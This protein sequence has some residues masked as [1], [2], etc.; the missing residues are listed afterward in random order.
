[1]AVPVPATCVC[2]GGG[3][4]VSSP[5]QPTAD[6]E[7][8]QP[9]A[10][11]RAQVTLGA[12]APRCAALTSTDLH[13]TS[14]RPPAAAHEAVLPQP[15]IALR[16]QHR[17]TRS[18]RRLAMAKVKYANLVSRVHGY[19]PDAFDPPGADQLRRS[20]RLWRPTTACSVPFSVLKVTVASGEGH[21]RAHQFQLRQGATALAQQQVNTL[22]MHHQG[23]PEPVGGAG[24]ARHHCTR[25]TQAHAIQLSHQALDPA[26][27]AAAGPHGIHPTRVC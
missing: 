23:H 11:A 25:D 2:G 5:P 10:I 14:V 4:L 18:S 21:R 8:M 16:Q 9:H 27:A 12:P 7:R 13:M 15:Q 19:G 20:R 3:G 17:N 22:P 26:R 1:M 24:S 6:P